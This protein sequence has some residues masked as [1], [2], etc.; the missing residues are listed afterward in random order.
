MKIEMIEIA[1]FASAMKA[2]RLPYK[3]EMKSKYDVRISTKGNTIETHNEVDVDPSDIILFQALNKKGDSHAKA[4]RGIQVYLEVEAPIYWWCEMETYQMGRT[5]L[6]SASTMHTDARGLKD[7]ELVK[8][9]A[10]MPMGKELRK[11]DCY[12]Y[13]MLRNVVKQRSC[14]R[15]P[16]WHQF[17]DFVHKLPFA[18]ELI[19]ANNEIDRY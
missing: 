16:E 8:V 11:I 14:H 3:N 10:Q 5:R 4:L 13:Q 19:F 7:K 12:S 18:E 9:K 2:L 17:I 6:C 1:G 15:L